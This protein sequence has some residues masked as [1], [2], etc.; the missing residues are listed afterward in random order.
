MA[1]TIVEA[2]RLM[3]CPGLA[4]LTGQ[5]RGTIHDWLATGTYAPAVA[6]KSLVL[7]GIHT[8]RFLEALGADINRTA[9][10]AS[11]TLKNIMEIDA[12]P[13]SLAWP[14]VKLYYASLFYAHATLRI[15]GRSPSYF[16]TLEL[17]PLRNALTAYG[18]AAPFKVQTG[19]Y[20]LTARMKAF[21]VDM[22]PD[23]SGGGSHES[24][25]REFHRALSDLQAAVA[26]APYLNADK[27]KI[28]AQLK[29]LLALIS[30]N[31]RNLSWPSQMRN[32]IQYRQAEGVWYPYQGKTKTSAL[33][34]EVATLYSGQADFSKLMSGT[35]TDLAQLRS[36][37]T[38]IICFAR[39]VI[40]DMSAV[41][42]SRSFL[43][44]GQRKFE[45]AMVDHA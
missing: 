2:A 18:V 10:A 5:P 4:Q 29:S 44:H 17:M 15:W 7:S 3:W 11:E 28:E 26:S 35:G 37:C 25:W 41:G 20:L 32:D 23:S 8:Q 22:L 12:L 40:A 39:G 30:K 31:G 6:S 9:S 34:Q 21:A 42:G 13:K 27:K 43:R 24:V 14:Y 38:A 45:D 1:L 33:R 16:R 19:Q 36:A